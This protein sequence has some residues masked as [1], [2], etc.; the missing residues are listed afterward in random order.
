MTMPNLNLDLTKPL[1]REEGGVRFGAHGDLPA[2]RGDTDATRG[3]RFPLSEGGFLL[4]SGGVI[5]DAAGTLELVFTPESCNASGALVQAWGQYPP[6][7]EL[8]GNGVRVNV[9]GAYVELMVR[10]EAEREVRLR[11]AW[12]HACGFTLS[13]KPRGK[14][15]Q[16]LRRRCAWQAFR[17]QY[18]PF[19]IGGTATE[20]RFRH[21]TPTFTGWVKSVRVWGEPVDVPGPVQVAPGGAPI[22]PP[23]KPVRGV[24]VL[25]LDDPPI[26]P[27]PL[28]L[29]MLPRRSLSDLRKTREVCELD[30]LLSHCKTER[31]VFAMLTWHLGALWPHC[32]YWPWPPREQRWIFWKRGHEILPEIRAGRAGGMCG[33]YAHM[34]EEVFWALGFDARRIQVTGHSSFEAHSNELDRWIVC[35]ASFNRQC[36]LLS[37]AQGRFLGAAD[38]I[39][40]HEAAEHDPEALRDVRQFVC[41]EENL[42]E[43]T[44]T[45][46]NPMYG[47]APV[48]AYDH[49]G[50]VMDM[51]HA[52][53]RSRSI[54]RS[55]RMAWYFRP[56]ERAWGRHPSM[57]NGKYEPVLV[58][59]LDELTPSRNRVRVSM[60]WDKPGDRLAVAAEPA[61]VTFFETLLAARDGGAEER[62][63]GAFGW[64][65]HPGV[66]TLTVRTLNRLGAKGYP[67]R[68]RVWRQP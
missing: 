24:K 40:R 46:T 60:S 8:G 37:D 49:L 66:N 26:R 11:L 64:K 52:Y 20:P 33:G 57:M 47:A 67:Y 39:R 63:K 41:R 6:L 2:P 22:R 17:Q 35:D 38:I 44:V 19:S 65:L 5:D 50:T 58:D 68:I 3:L 61:G 53:G 7:V 9:Y 36:H 25:E 21:W 32:N 16:V 55:T 45:P 62:T 34:M 28:G 42:V 31:E 23:F 59:N 15:E 12:H 30:R 18:V 13:V 14:P 10:L 48:H 51:T 54:C 43:S 29:V 1:S 56:C 4:A 27:D